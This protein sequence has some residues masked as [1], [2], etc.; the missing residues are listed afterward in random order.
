[1][2]WM[3]LRLDRIELRLGHRGLVRPRRNQS[4]AAMV[5][6]AVGS[7]ILLALLSG[8]FELGYTFIQY[9]KLETAVAQGARYASLVPYD[10]STPMPS[11]GFLSAVKNVVL[12]GSPETGD[13]PVVNGLSVGNIN[14][15]VSFKDGVPS[16]MEVSITGYV[17]NALFRNHTLEGKPRATYPYQGIWAPL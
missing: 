4:G 14:L 17:V 10:S 7:G 15:N 1:M 13:T 16:S 11:A 6:F 2:R 3:P 5:E 8:T 12:Y 9:N